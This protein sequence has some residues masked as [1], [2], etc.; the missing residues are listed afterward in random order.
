MDF[1]RT[2]RQTGRFDYGAYLVSPAWYALRAKVRHRDGN[3]C[4]AC[5]SGKQLDVHHRTYARIGNERLA[6]LV[7]LCRSCHK[8]THE[9]VANKQANLYVAHKQVQRGIHPQ[10][11][12]PKKRKK[13]QPPKRTKAPANPPVLKVEKPKKRRPTPAEIRE[14]FATTCR[15][16]RAEVQPDAKHCPKCLTAKPISALSAAEWDSK[17]ARRKGRR[18]RRRRQETQ[19]EQR[20]E[21]RRAEREQRLEVG[22]PASRRA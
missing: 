14:R 10:A 1:T 3:K 16:C 4:R 6:D 18:Q 17:T 9:L 20:R 15:S 12:K 11:P 7:T 22:T 8:A 13:P 21:Q 2:P 5:G 19:Y